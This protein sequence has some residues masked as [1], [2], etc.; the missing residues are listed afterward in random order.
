MIG[1]KILVTDGVNKGLVGVVMT[2]R[3]PS[4]AL[5]DGDKGLTFI[6]AE[7]SL[8]WSYVDNVEEYTENDEL[9]QLRQ[10]VKELEHELGVERLRRRRLEWEL[11][12]EEQF[13]HYEE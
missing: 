8:H 12:D 10:R 2:Y 9:N 6:T 3:D 4:Q 5:F 13:D 1:K 7:G 11:L